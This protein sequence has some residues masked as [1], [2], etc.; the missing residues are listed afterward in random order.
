M[1]SAGTIQPQLTGYTTGDE[2]YQKVWKSTLSKCISLTQC[3]CNET[4]THSSTL[5]YSLEVTRQLLMSPHTPVPIVANG[6]V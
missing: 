2:V 5:H 6:A 1:K 4:L 3:F